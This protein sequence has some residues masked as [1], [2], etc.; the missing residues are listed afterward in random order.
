MMSPRSR[1]WSWFDVA[2]WRRVD[3]EGRLRWDLDASVR[4][5]D[6]VA[7]WWGRM[8]CAHDTVDVI[9]Q[10]LGKD[11]RCFVLLRQSIGV[12]TQCQFSLPHGACNKTAFV[13]S[14]DTQ[15]E[16]QDET[17]RLDE[18]L[19]LSRVKLTAKQLFAQGDNCCCT[20]QT[21]HVPKC[22]C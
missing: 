21:K 14:L 13:R 20:N 5:D 11:K 18:V 10:S 9:K 15:S 6:F 17:K 2:S 3:S 7:G 22:M 4:H 16:K 19:C 1:A 12:T 8:P